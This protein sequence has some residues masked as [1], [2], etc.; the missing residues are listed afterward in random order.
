MLGTV[1]QLPFS[2][3]GQAL[4]FFHQR[5]PARQR[6]VNFFE[7]ER[8]QKPQFPDFSGLSPTD[9]WASVANAIWRTL[10]DARAE[11]RRAFELAFLNPD[12]ARALAPEEIA[13]VLKVSTSTV[14]RYLRTL[15]EELELELKRRELMAW[16]QE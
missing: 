13:A 3:A 4:N 16:D 2:S 6:Y 1:S 14:Y 11:E 10:K 8:G 9:V 7:P 12:R 15:R 5:N